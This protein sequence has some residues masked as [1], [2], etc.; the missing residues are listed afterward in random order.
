MSSAGSAIAGILY[1]SGSGGTALVA[2]LLGELL[3]GRLEREVASIEDLRAREIAAGADLLVFLYPTYYLKP[4]PSMAEFARALGPFE[5]PKL[6]Y[7]VTT[8]ELY[9]ENSVRRLS[10]SL[11]SRGIRVAGSKVVHATGSDVTLAVPSGLV[12]WWYR[13]ERALP[14]K[15]RDIADEVAAMAETGEA[16]ERIPGLK[17]YTPLT[18]LVQVLLLNRFDA[19]RSRVRVLP[20]RCSGCGSCVAMCGRGAWAM[21]PA[22]PAHDPERCDLCGRCL[23]SC[24]GRAIV[25]LRPLR[26]NRRLDAL[27]YS[28]L[29][30][31]ARSA[32]GLPI[33]ADRVGTRVA[34]AGRSRRG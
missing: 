25:L 6:A 33:P 27:L 17:W 4:A 18:Q 22:L 32:L 19:F 28:R 16:D 23:H 5:P 10:L 26:D 24:P 14:R 15:L 9:T 12:P 13:F 20:D 2:E 29:G 34:A 21:G 7:V 3:S 11:R 31:E 8:C 1:F 30:D